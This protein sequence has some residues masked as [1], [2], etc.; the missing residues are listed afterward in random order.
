MLKRKHI[1]ILK[2]LYKN[3][4][5]RACTSIQIAAHDSRNDFKSCP[6]LEIVPKA[7]YDITMIE[8]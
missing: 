4:T 3:P 1:P 2:I 7:S 8:R 6:Y 5:Q